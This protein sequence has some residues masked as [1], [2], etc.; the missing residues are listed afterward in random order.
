MSNDPTAP[1]PLTY[2]PPRSVQAADSAGEPP[3]VVRLVVEIR[4][5]G[6]TTIARAGLGD[7][8]NGRGTMLEA[9]GSTPLALAL[10]LARHLVALS[11]P[12]VSRSRPV[13]ANSLSARRP[14]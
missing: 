8:L 2:R 12:L 13:P 6:A 14:L 9:R 4:S 7:D 1:A 3:V 10:S 11:R 5:D